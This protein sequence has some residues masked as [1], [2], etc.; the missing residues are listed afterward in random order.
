MSCVWVNDAE[1][2]NYILP[3]K[4]YQRLCN[5]GMVLLPKGKAVLVTSDKKAI[6]IDKQARYPADM[7]AIFEKIRGLRIKE[8]QRKV[9]ENNGKNNAV[10]LNGLVTDRIGRADDI[11][12]KVIGYLEP[13]AAACLFLAV[14]F[15]H[16]RLNP[17][18]KN[19]SLNCVKDGHLNL[20]LWSKF[21]LPQIRNTLCE[22]AAKKGYEDILKALHRAGYPLGNALYEAAVNGH[23]NLVLNFPF[24]RISYCQHVFNY[25]AKKG[26]VKMFSFCLEKSNQVGPFVAFFAAEA[27]SIEI[28]KILKD[29]GF[30]NRGNVYEGA[31]RGDRIAVL[32]WLK[33]IDYPKCN[34]AKKYAQE[35][36]KS[37]ILDWLKKNDFPS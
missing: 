25:Y 29:K 27:G 6:F 19:F 3:E 9:A 31:I 10:L 20:F 35:T 2:R 14:K 24:E 30:L 7:Q 21:P 5:K 37:H 13:S 12:T 23:E 28:L 4:S 36:N 15:F 32:E 22:E 8:V 16:G 18:F 1:G 33:S 26:N 17:D 34:A 11:W